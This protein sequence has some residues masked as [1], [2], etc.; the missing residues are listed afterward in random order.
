MSMTNE[1]FGRQPQVVIISIAGSE[2]I[3]VMEWTRK[4]E[5]YCGNAGD[6][7]Q[8]DGRVRRDIVNPAIFRAAFTVHP[9]AV[10]D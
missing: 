6:H 7:V 4:L 5:R 8:W 1:P 2:T 10:N 3:D 9:R